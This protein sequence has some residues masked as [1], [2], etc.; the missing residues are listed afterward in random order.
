[1]ESVTTESVPQNS[2]NLT[3]GSILS[4]PSWFIGRLR[5]IDDML[6]QDLQTHQLAASAAAMQAQPG[7]AQ[8]LAGR[9]PE[10]IPYEMVAMPGPLAFITSGYAVGLLAMVSVFRYS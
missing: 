4:F 5:R 8:R 3:L 9:H 1:M 7:R 6:Q 2:I 10:G